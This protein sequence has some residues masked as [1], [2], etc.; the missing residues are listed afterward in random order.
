MIEEHEFIKSLLSFE[1][2]KN[3]IIFHCKTNQGR[4]VDVELTVCSPYILRFR[5]CPDEKLKSIK[6]LLEIKENW[7]PCGFDVIEETDTVT[8]DTGIL[9]FKVKKEPWTYTIY[10]KAGEIILKENTSDRDAHGNYRSLP[11]GFTVENGKFCKSNETF[12][13]L[14]GECFYGFGEKFT[15]FNKLGQRIR[16]WNCNPFGAGTEESYKNIPFFISNRGYGIF[17]NSTYPIIFE[18]GNRSLMT[19]TILVDD[20]RLDLFIIYGPSLKDVLARYVEITGFPSLPPKESFG[21]WHTPYFIDT[22][23][24]LATPKR[25]FNFAYPL[26]SNE[27][28]DENIV[29]EYFDSVEETAK[30]FRE[31]DIPIDIFMCVGFG[32]TPLHAREICER[33]KPYGIKVGMYVAPLLA[34]GRNIEKEARSLGY[35]LKK[36]DGSPYE[37]PL[38]FKVYAGERGVPEYSL[39]A[40]ERTEAWRWRHNKI[41]YELCLMP[42]FTNPEAVKWWKNKIAEYM[43]AGCFG[44]AMSDF[45]EDVPADACYYNGRPGKEMH[46]IYTLLYQKA[47]YEAVAESTGHRGLVNARSGYAGM[48]KY[49]ICWSGDPNCEWEDFLANIRAGLSMGLSGIPFWSCDNGGYQSNIGHLTPELWI[50]WTQWSMFTSHVRLHGEPPPRVPWVFGEKALEIFRKYAKLRYRLLPY[51]YSQSYIATRTGLPLMRAMILEFQEDPN[52]YNIEDQYVFGDSFLVAP[53]C[54]PSGKRSIYLPKGIWFDYWTGKEYEGPAILSLNVPIDVLPLYVKGDSIIPMGPDMS[55]VGEKPF[56][57]ITLD[58]WLCSEAETILYDDDEIVNCRA[59][60]KEDKILLE[61]GASNK[62][63]IVK[64]NKTSCPLEVS[65][66]NVNLPKAANYNEFEKSKRCW[67]F[68]NSF[69]VYI[70][71][72]ALGITNK[73]KLQY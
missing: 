24:W 14:P 21:I 33:L 65:L 43:K 31:L 12:S 38:G 30:K 57:P 6:S 17:V 13:I 66:N 48:Q 59:K 45:G 53:V 20:P 11:L 15:K 49:P 8:V 16:C 47:T 41:F 68:D 54:S 63:Y 39:E 36:S 25:K 46:N 3:G 1:K 26:P 72:D 19:Y 50:R 42:D 64:F 70:K 69:I 9:Y 5:M 32:V 10:D 71:F 4:T 23:P 18:M 52:C 40:I 73:V 34:L 44:V 2:I 62:T 28:L 35:V 7:S 37:I 56:N 51:I 61:I 67:Y 29:K 55:Y 58:I 22:Q 60:K 27:K